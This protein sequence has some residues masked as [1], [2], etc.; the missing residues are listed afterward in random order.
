MRNKN[1]P[2][3]KIMTEYVRR[4]WEYV[5]QPHIE[6]V[7]GTI[8]LFP[9]Y[10]GNGRLYENRSDT[11]CVVLSFTESEDYLKWRLNTNKLDMDDFIFQYDTRFNGLTLTK[12]CWFNGNYNS[13]M[14]E[15]YNEIQHSVPG[16]VGAMKYNRGQIIIYPDK[17]IQECTNQSSSLQ[18]KRKAPIV[19]LFKCILLVA[20]LVLLIMIIRPA[21][22]VD[23]IR[24]AF[25]FELPNLRDI[26]INW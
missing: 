2:C 3:I 21:P 25:H 26:K 6:E 8:M 10:S 24:N 22:I 15:L 14:K 19:R 5:H 11:I 12:E 4:L 1:L 16:I 23:I 7:C 13:V 9:K 18:E 17:G 20:I